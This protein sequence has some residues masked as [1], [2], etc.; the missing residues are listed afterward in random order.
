M[1]NWSLLCCCLAFLYSRLSYSEHGRRRRADAVRAH[2]NLAVWPSVSVFFIICCAL[3]L[4]E[5]IVRLAVGCYNYIVAVTTTVLNML[6]FAITAFI[7]KCFPI[8]NTD[9]IPAL[10]KSLGKRLG[11]LEIFYLILGQIHLQIYGWDFCFCAS[12]WTLELHYINA[13]GME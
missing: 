6:V 11:H 9:F 7:F 1:W 4:I 10:E 8:W 3:S 13:S 12:C 2:F 5:I